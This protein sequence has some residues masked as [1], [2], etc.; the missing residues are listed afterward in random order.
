M[1]TKI[2]GVFETFICKF[3]GYMYIV[4][5]ETADFMLTQDIVSRDFAKLA[6]FRWDASHTQSNYDYTKSVK[7]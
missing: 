7:I 5:K 4:I 3:I 2:V 6:T 1:I